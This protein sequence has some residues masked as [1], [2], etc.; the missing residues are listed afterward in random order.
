MA[1]PWQKVKKQ[2]KNHFGAKKQN[3]FK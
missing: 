1:K 2:N 3:P